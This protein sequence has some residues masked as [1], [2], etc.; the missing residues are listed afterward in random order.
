MNS[1]PSIVYP[2]SYLRSFRSSC[3]LSRVTRPNVLLAG[4][5]GSGKSSIVNSI[6]GRELATAGAGKPIT[7]HYT[8]YA[9]SVP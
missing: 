5:S 1:H 7:Q 2:I 4:A 8:K 9:P 6:F 3:L